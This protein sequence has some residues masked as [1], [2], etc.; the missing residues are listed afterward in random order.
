MNRLL[1]IGPQGAGKGTQAAKVCA[2]LGIPHIST[3]D[4]FRANISAGTDLGRQVQAYIAD[5]ELV[6]D[7]VTQDMLTVRLAESDA[8]H[9]WLLDG[10]PRNTAQAV[11]LTA[12]LDTIGAPLDAVILLTAPDET[13]V[14]RMLARGRGDDT[15]EAITNRLDIYHSETAPLIGY[16]DERVIKVDGVG[17]IDEVHER[18]L[19][20]LHARPGAV[21]GE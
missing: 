17:N 1:I 7:Q 10:F 14:Q 18:I 2:A 11:W 6:P 21:E 3:G 20:A 19:G 12:E 15:V 5:G 4:L 16:Y 8:Q 13:V 9:G